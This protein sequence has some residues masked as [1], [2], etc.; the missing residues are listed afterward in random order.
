MKE[1]NFEMIKIDGNKVKLGDS[2]YLPEAWHE[3]ILVKTEK[4]IF[5]ISTPLRKK[6]SWIKKF[7]YVKV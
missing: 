4:K 5:H 1:R 6:R 3:N 2:I 7:L